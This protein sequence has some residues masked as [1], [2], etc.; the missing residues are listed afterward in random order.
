MEK[1]Y[2]MNTDN[3]S[4]RLASVAEFVPRGARLLDVGSDHAYLPINLVKSG[5]I[6]FAIAGEVVQGPFDS[7][8]DNVARSNLT[9]KIQ[10]RLADGLAAFDARD[11]IDTISICG[12][13][14]HLI[15]DI[16]QAGLAKLEPVQNLI[17]QPNNGEKYLRTW[18]MNHHFKVVNE[19]IVV[20]NDKTY[21]IIIAKHGDEKLSEFDLTFGKYLRAKTPA[22]FFQK[23]ERELLALQAILAKLPENASEKRQEFSE[24]IAMVEEILND[25]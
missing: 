20:E 5:Q 1:K 3:L 6:E 22:G 12:M 13:G 2:K 21:E 24:K 8:R 19:D 25:R 17:L 16:L 11:E 15:A 23:W 10:V 4:K 9:D 14:G 7:A 18:L